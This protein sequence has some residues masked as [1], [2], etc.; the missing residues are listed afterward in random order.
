[1]D[2]AGQADSKASN[3]QLGRFAHCR[4]A[5]SQERRQGYAAMPRH[6]VS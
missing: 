1:M 3:K 5:V 4:G 2:L 6:H